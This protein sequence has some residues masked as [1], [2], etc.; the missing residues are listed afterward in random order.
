MSEIADLFHLLTSGVY[1]VGVADGERRDAFTAAWVMQASF[2]PLLLAVSVNR[3]NAS[4][5]ILRS[6]RSFTVN[7]LRRGQLDLAS[8]FGTR[9]GRDQDKLAGVRWRPGRRG[10]PILEDALAYFECELG[11]TVPAGDHELVLGR[12]V[13]GR[14]LAPGAAPMTYAETGE[15][16]GSRELYPRG[17]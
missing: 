14:I 15:M 4:Y 7:V 10:A 17:F 2:E 8:G 6:G 12:V 9:S 11:E 1:V 13:D 5:S 16:D 3:E